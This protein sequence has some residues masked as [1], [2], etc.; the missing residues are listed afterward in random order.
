MLAMNR[1]GLS[2]GLNMRRHGPLLGQLTRFACVGVAATMTHVLVALVVTWAFAFSPLVANF[3]GFCVAVFVSFWGHSRVTFRVAIPQRRH[4]FR[5]TVLSL[6]SLGVSS[7]ITV[8]MTALG[9]S[10][11]MAMVAVGIIVPIVSF[12]AA[13][14]WAFAAI[15][16]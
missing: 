14:L 11:T 8:A 13:R 2:S 10:M 1:I 6:V 7:V 4:L 16:D 9:A 5:F 15:A 12:L 3:F